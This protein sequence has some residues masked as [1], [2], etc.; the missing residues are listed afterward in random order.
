V[1]RIPRGLAVLG[2]AVALAVAGCVP[3]SPDLGT[4]SAVLPTPTSNPN[5]P[6]VDATATA[7]I[8]A[9]GAVATVATRSLR[10]RALPTVD[11]EQIGSVLSGES[12]AVTARSTDGMWL[13]LEIPA[14]G[15]SGWVAAD[16]VSMA[17]DITDLPI[18]PV[19]TPVP[20][21]PTP[22][23]TPTPTP[24]LEPV[25]LPTPTPEGGEPLTD[26]VPITE[27]IVTTETVPVEPTATP[28]L[29]QIVPPPAGSV[30][31]NTEVRLRV[32]AEPSLEAAIVGYAYP[33]E[34]FE[35]IER[36]ADGAWTRIAGNP[37]SQENPSGGWVASE[38]LLF[39]E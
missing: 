21:T 20:P 3:I 28:A 16:L 11:S 22:T 34:V 1:I 6:V 4:G 8:E 7:I 35:V 15:G 12:F 18:V 25:E 26:T 2:L 39:G 30:A 24:T 19:P 23:R 32:R 5:A 14:L 38:F 13:E 10:V 31:I 36:S 37:A 9:G 27:T 17:G 29:G 33:G